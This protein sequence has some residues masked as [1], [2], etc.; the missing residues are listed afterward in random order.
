VE[1]RTQFEVDLAMT[2]VQHKGPEFLSGETFMECDKGVLVQKELKSRENRKT[3]TRSWQSLDVKYEDI[4]NHILYRK[5]NSL[6]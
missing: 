2:V 5:A 1:L 6:Q 3:A 4:Y